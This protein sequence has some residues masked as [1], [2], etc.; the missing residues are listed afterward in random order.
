MGYMNYILLVILVLLS[1]F[2]S[3]SETAF[4]S[5]SL[6]KIKAQANKGDIRAKRV[7]KLLKDETRLL[8]AILI[9]NNLV[10]IG[11]SAISTSIAIEIFGNSGVAIATGIVTLIILFFGE[12]T[13]KSLGNI[14]SIKF[15]KVVAIYLIW[16]EKILLPVII[17][18]SFII[19]KMLGEKK[20]VSA[21]FFSEEEIKRFVNVS[22]E[23]GAIKETESEMI[24]SIFDFDDTLVKEIMVPRIDMVCINKNA[25]IDELVD[26]AV[27]N[28]HSRIPVYE[29]SIDEIIGLVYVKDLLSLIS[30]TEKNDEEKMKLE[31]FI[32]PIYFIP[33][34]KPINQLLAEMKNRKEHM[35]IVVD[36]YGGTSGLITIEDL[37]E[38]IVGDIQDEYDYE[39]K[40]IKIIGE[41]EM[42]VDG[43]VDIDDINQV[44]PEL[45][46]DRDDYETISGFVLHHLGYFPKEGEKLEIEELDIEIKETSEHKIDKVRIISEEPVRIKE[47]QAGV[48]HVK[49]D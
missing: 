49:K 13:P 3:G 38:E 16:I 33:E 1:G 18:F 45:I 37:L 24:H 25:G 26:L 19:K 15:A 11:A 31:N 35:A 9:G 14:K 42:L 32:K 2:F 17:I 7:L 36:E 47:N 28:G 44:L 48:L 43:Q 46:L 10:N 30:F 6:V 23:E 27:E 5:V 39:P 21:T 20:L 41:H 12:I 8:T 4:M 29:E 34:S 40:Q 22:E